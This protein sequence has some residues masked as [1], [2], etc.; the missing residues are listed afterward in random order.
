[1]NVY[2]TCIYLHNQIDTVA[3]Y[4]YHRVSDYS[5]RHNG[6][7]H[8]TQRSVEYD[9]A[10]CTRKIYFGFFFCFFS[11]LFA[12]I[13]ST[14]ARGGFSCVLRFRSAL[15]LF[16]SMLNGVSSC[17]FINSLLMYLCKCVRRS[18]I[19]YIM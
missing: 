7:F 9:S 11:F 18:V 1:M 10:H 2:R 16:G 5:A 8:R 6:P 13:L 12:F 15:F 3:S 4:C 14:G 17:F 19:C